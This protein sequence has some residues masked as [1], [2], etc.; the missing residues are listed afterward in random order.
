MPA[1]VFTNPIK[2]RQTG[3][4]SFTLVDEN[5]AG[6]NMNTILTMTLTYY[7]KETLTIIN[8]RQDQNVLNNNNVTVNTVISPTLVTTVTWSFRPEDTIVVDN[9]HEL[10]THVAL[11]QWTWGS[12]PV[13]HAAHEMEFQIENLTYVP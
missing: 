2:E 1:T 12:N 10:E 6:I 13:L 4:Y 5:D 11:F 9:R 7:D 8:N 3:A